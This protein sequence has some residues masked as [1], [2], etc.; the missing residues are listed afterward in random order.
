M[1]YNIIR[2]ILVKILSHRQSSLAIVYKM[3][4]IL[5]SM[6]YLRYILRQLV[7]IPLHIKIWL[8]IICCKLII[9]LVIL[10][11]IIIGIIIIFWINL[12]LMLAIEVIIRYLIKIILLLIMI[13]M[14]KLIIVCLLS[15]LRVNETLNRKRPRRTWNLL[16]LRFHF[17]L[18]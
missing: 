4:K 1:M 12:V 17:K 13:L 10:H 11:W 5:L 16:S 2:L 3:I 9:R 7:L 8:I 15:N 14:S 18:N 6:I